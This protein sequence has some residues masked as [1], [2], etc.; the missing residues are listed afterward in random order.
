MGRIPKDLLAR[1]DYYHSEVDELF[2]RL[3]GDELGTGFE[4]EDLS[5][6]I[7]LIETE[8]EFVIRIDL[9]GIES[10]A[11]DLHAAQNFLLLRCEK[12]LDE[13]LDSDCLRMERSFGEIQRLLPIP[14][15]ADA[16]RV[17]A[18]YKLGVLEV[19][20]P[21]IMDRRKTQKRIDIT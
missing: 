13:S 19:R 18:S 4:P 3:F 17:K 5:A 9:P 7:D 21:K 2:Q 10:E 12:L 20:M 16:A 15:A 14:H 6:G 11:I 1:L 8:G